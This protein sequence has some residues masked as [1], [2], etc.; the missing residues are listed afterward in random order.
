MGPYATFSEGLSSG[1]QLSAIIFL[2]KCL[3]GPYPSVLVVMPL[4]INTELLIL[5]TQKV[6]KLSCYS[7]L[8][9][10]LNPLNN[11][12]MNLKNQGYLWQ[13]TTKISPLETL[14]TLVSNM[15]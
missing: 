2:N 10:A 4:G 6:G 5:S 7:R 9:M 15:L 3:D 8:Q 11:L 13:C 12:L 14:H 1:N